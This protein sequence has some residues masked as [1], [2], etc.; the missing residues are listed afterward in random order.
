M[1]ETKYPGFYRAVVVDN[2]D[3]K[4]LNRIRMIVPQVSGESVT[5]WAWPI[6]STATIPE[7]SAT[8]WAAFEG[9]DPNFPLWIGTL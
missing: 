6:L 2:Y 5:D 7:A 8:L 1:H 4:N 3:P 9:G